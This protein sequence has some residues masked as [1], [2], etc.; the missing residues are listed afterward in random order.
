MENKKVKDMISDIAIIVLILAFLALVTSEIITQIRINNK[1]HEPE[2]C[3]RIN[4]SYYC[5]VD[6]L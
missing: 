1:I 4:K 6:K 5:K 2:N 3:I